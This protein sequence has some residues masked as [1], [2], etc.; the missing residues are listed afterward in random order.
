VAP[1]SK[2]QGPGEEDWVRPAKDVFVCA[3]D[4]VEIEDG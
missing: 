3:T 4:V 1:Q 2:T